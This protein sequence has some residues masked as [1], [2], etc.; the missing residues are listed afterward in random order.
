MC[1]L[2]RAGWWGLRKKPI[3]CY[4]G[5]ALDEEND[6]LLLTTTS[7]QRRVL[8]FHSIIYMLIITLNPVFIFTRSPL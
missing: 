4:D 1:W 2:L 8:I 3:V 5:E 6:T 7:L